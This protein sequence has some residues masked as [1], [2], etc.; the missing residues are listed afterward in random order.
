MTTDMP[1]F[2]PPSVNPNSHD[3]PPEQGTLNIGLGQ[4]ML[5]RQSYQPSRDVVEFFL[6]F[7]PIPEQA[8]MK[9]G[10]PLRVAAIK[11]RI[12][13]N[14]NYVL[15]GVTDIMGD[16]IISLAAW[17]GHD[18]KAWDTAK[19]VAIAQRTRAEAAMERKEQGR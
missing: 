18:R 15:Y 4:A 3:S 10:L 12:I 8:W 7:E 2:T 17:A 13:A 1:R 16:Q 11:R 6:T 14:L 9:A 5:E 19:Q